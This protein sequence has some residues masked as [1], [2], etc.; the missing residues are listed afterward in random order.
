MLVLS[1]LAMLAAFVPSTAESGD[2]V[3][4]LI[5][6]STPLRAEPDAKARAVAKLARFDIVSG[7]EA[8]KGWLQID[9]TTS[10][11][12]STNGW[13]PLVAD[14]IVPG[15]LEAV[16]RRVFRV[17]ENKWP[18]QVKLDVLRGR[19][20]PG[21]SGYQVQLAIGDPLKKELR[22]VGNDVMEEWI[23]ADRRVVFSHDGVKAVEPIAPTQ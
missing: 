6:E 11:A 15:P 21:F 17:Q 4:Y 3:L 1:L 20:R 13:V 5:V 16:R 18:D 22:H 10:A 9:A 8:V 23:Y 7:K 14:N 12:G 2:V 19:V